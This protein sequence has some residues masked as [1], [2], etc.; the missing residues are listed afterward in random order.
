MPSV[1]DDSPGSGAFSSPGS[2]P[3]ESAVIQQGLT[4]HPDRW[5]GDYMAA[6]MVAAGIDAV[7]ARQVADEMQPTIVAAFATLN[8]LEF[9]GVLMQ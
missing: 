8:R 3:A 2:T 6:Q 9:P 5:L 7:A 4:R 1:N